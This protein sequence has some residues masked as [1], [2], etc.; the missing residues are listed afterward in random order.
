[1]KI[2]KRKGLRNE[3]ALPFLAVGTQEKRVSLH[4]CITMCYNVIIMLD[5]MRQ[6]GIGQDCKTQ[7]A[8][9]EIYEEKHLWQKETLQ[10]T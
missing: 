6:K 1:M 10:Q 5:A 4:N 9:E 3:D 7:A 8:V 2:I